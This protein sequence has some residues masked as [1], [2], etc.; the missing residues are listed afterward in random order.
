MLQRRRPGLVHGA[1]PGQSA[2]RAAHKTPDDHESWGPPRGRFTCRR[3]RPTMDLRGVEPLTSRLSG[4]RSNQLSYRSERILEYT[5]RADK[6]Q[7]ERSRRATRR[8]AAV[9]RACACLIFDPERS[10]PVRPRPARP[11][12]RR[13]LTSRMLDGPVVAGIVL[14]GGAV[15]VGGYFYVEHVRHGRN[16][17]RST[18]VQERL[19][20]VRRRPV[21]GRR[22]E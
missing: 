19:P 6:R 22:G 15:L 14:A 9:P 2:H 4:V 8:S 17:G 11:L 13:T 16:A 1:A 5:F 12:F 21:D 7:P 3:R 10:V 20:L 18:R